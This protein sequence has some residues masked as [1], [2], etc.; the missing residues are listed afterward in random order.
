[1]ITVKNAEIPLKSAERLITLPQGIPRS[2]LCEIRLRVGRPAMAVSVS[3]TSVPCSR[4]LS[5]ADIDGC[6]QELCRYSVHSFQREIAEGYITL[7]G[8]HRAG[9]CGT[10]MVRGG[11]VEALRSISSINIRIAHEIKGCAEALHRAVFSDGMRSLLI[12]GAPLTG[13]TTLLRDLARLIGENHKVALI[14]SRSELAACCD[15]APQLDI[16][17][18]TDVLNGYPRAEGMETALR[19]LSPEVIICDELGSD[20]GAVKRCANCGVKLIATIH[21]DSAQQLLRG[22]ETAELCGAFDCIAVV[23]GKGEIAEIRETNRG[24]LCADSGCKP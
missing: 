7:P 14:D 18:N 21:A 16:G 8:G 13:K 6:F 19:T 3:G 24:G 22:K 12:A 2:R 17:L 4:T 15:G 1:M 5:A 23:R 20:I 9:F 11:C 10:A